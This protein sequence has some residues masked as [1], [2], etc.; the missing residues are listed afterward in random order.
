M[1][2]Q[3]IF[4]FMSITLLAHNAFG[5]NTDA[6]NAL[7]LELW[8]KFQFLHRGPIAQIDLIDYPQE[9]KGTIHELKKD[10]TDS[11]ASVDNA[12]TIDN[13]DPNNPRLVINIS[14]IW[15]YPLDASQE[16]VT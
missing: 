7:A 13:T 11:L 10:V 15:S 8:Q 14:K 6:D 4:I 2:K 12:L 1:N 9:F 16:E 3:L 5:M